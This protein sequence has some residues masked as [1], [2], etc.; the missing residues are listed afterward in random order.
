MLLTTPT[1]A[2]AENMSIEPISFILDTQGVYVGRQNDSSVH[3]RWRA[4]MTADFGVSTVNS[5]YRAGAGG[6]PA[7]TLIELLVCIAI[8][9]AFCALVL[10]SLQPTREAARRSQCT[11]NLMQLGLG[12]LNYHDAHRTFPP[13][14]VSAVGPAGDD[15]GPGWG[16]G[17]MLLPFIEQGL[18]WRHIDFDTH[19]ESE[20]NS[21]A[22]AQRLELFTCPSD[23]GHYTYVACF[24]RGD[25][26]RNPDRGDG[27]F[28]RNSRVRLRDVDDGATTILI[29]ER[30]SAKGGA[31]WTGITATDLAFAVRNPGKFNADRSRVLGHTGPT[32]VGDPG[33][34]PLS[35]EAKR[36]A[37]VALGRVGGAPAA[38][39]NR[40]CIY[41]FGG[42]HT[43]GSN[44]VLVDGSV[45]FIANN[46]DSAIPPSLATRAGGELVTAADF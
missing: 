45:R 44:F 19:S 15:L 42:P 23:W 7:F 12:L 16:W 39:P 46:V 34:L 18:I 1:T 32:G 4:E 2:A 29:G 10:S 28:F 31:Q 24:G 8:I 5:Q 22:V 11:N 36:G 21:T 20:S 33:H 35:V 14:Y 38:A 40:G 26:D 25:V 27:M 41:D 17:A 6:R 37:G 9:A 13:G 30:A 43:T 3:S